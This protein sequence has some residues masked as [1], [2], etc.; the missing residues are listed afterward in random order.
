MT[1]THIHVLI[2]APSRQ[3]NQ[4]HSPSSVKGAG[5]Q[6]DPAVDDIDD[7][8]DAYGSN[9][10]DMMEGAT[11]ADADR[12]QLYA[13]EDDEDMDESSASAAAT[14]PLPVELV[15]VVM[16]FLDGAG[17]L[18]C[19]SVNSQ[20]HAQ[21]HRPHFWKTVCLARWPT[22]R[23]QLL[24]QLPGAP[25]Y[26]LI[27]LYGGCWKTCFLLNHQKSQMAECSVLIPDFAQCSVDRIVSET[28][29]I[30]DHHF[31]LWVFPRGNPHE[32]EYHEKSLSV[33][34]VLTDLDKRPPDWL[35]CAVFTLS[36]VHPTDPSK[37]IEWHSSLNDNKFN[38]SLYNWGVHSLGDIAF[39]KHKANGFVSNH[40]G[41]LHVT[42][43]V[44]L[45]SMSF[46]LHVEESFVAHEGLGLGA[47]PI[48]T[49][50][51]PFC[52]TLADLLEALGDAFP[53][54][55]IAQCRLWSFSHTVLTG[56]AKRPR[57]CL[58][59][60]TQT[61]TPLFG[62]LL[63]DGTDIDAYSST[64]LFLD[65]ACLDSFVF[66]KVLDRDT[67]T[68]R[69]LG[70]LRLSVYA[71]PAAI[72]AGFLA[73]PHVHLWHAVK[74]EC[75]PQLCSALLA[76]DETL[77]PADMVIFAVSRE[78]E[79]PSEWMDGVRRA[80]QRY[81]D[82]RYEMARALAAN[83]FHVVTLADVEALGELLDLPRF[84]IHSVFSKCGEDARRTLLYIMEGR[85]LGFICDAC[86]E[87]DF[88]GPR[89]NCRVCSDYDLCHGCY[90]HS[91]EVGHRYANVDGKWKRVANFDAHKRD[92]AM[93]HVLPVF[94]K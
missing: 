42:A 93:T 4:V 57:K 13:K 63:C 11:C 3:D 60:L 85:H 58:S 7:G 29:T 39:F 44:R 53:A 77:A 72:A 79:S 30:H 8:G 16:G 55:A 71:T 92:H 2:P 38:R 10:M 37:S 65:P 48:R 90:A 49:L 62:S 46:R 20:W 28:F 74:E 84:R 26:D 64:D 51:L 52:C 14:V 43:R 27:R 5:D 67:G 33:Y 81:L 70:R 41:T 54:L 9:Q 34:L 47:A 88:Q 24:P 75:A 89:Y 73:Y 68:L 66:V 61:S 21:T 56:Q 18:A 6:D 31:C 69:Y 23:H 32:P 36:V 25:D 1:N 80:L 15:S 82:Q 78:D 35:T 17:L 22:L 94:F 59:A 83:P 50:E 76:P 87:T 12:M 40:G 19:A 91:Q 86:G 45:M